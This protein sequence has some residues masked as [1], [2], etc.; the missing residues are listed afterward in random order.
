MY[1]MTSERNPHIYFDDPRGVFKQIQ[2]NRETLNNCKRHLFIMPETI[3][4][5]QKLK[6]SNC[7]GWMD[8]VHAMEYARGYQAAG[9]DPNEIIPGFYTEVPE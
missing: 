8:A 9:R 2:A 6:C 7:G 3:S 4:F 1:K 5:K